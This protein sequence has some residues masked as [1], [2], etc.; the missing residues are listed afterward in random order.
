MEVLFVLQKVLGEIFMD[1]IHAY[2]HN[3]KK[4]T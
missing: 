3:H 1:S 2:T 4:K